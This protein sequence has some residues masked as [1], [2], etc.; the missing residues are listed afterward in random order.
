MLSLLNPTI[1]G[2]QV[3]V[4]R[5]QLETCKDQLALSFFS[6]GHDQH[7]KGL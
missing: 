6:N 1:L 4:L 7:R 3:A 5:D 2:F